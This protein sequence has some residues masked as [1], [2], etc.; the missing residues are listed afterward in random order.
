MQVLADQLL[1]GITLGAMYA[2]VA[3]GLA[4]IFSVVQLVNFSQGDSFMIG[5]YVFLIIFAGGAI[6]YPVAAVLCVAIMALFGVVFE[7]I[8]VRPIFD[9]PWYIQLLSTLAAS[10]ILR[11][12]ARLIWG[13]TP[14]ATPTSYVGAFLRI[15]RFEVSYQR[16][17]VLVVAVLSFL[18]LQL[19]LQRTRLGKAMR[20]VSQNREASS[21]VGIDIR[22]MSRLT[23]A[24]S[25]ALAGLGAVV[26]S[27]LFNIFPDMGASL[28]LRAFAA[29]V[30]GG[31]GQVKG[32]IY[33]ALLLGIAEALATGYVSAAYKDLVAFT[34]IVVVL[35]IRP[36]GLFGQRKVGSI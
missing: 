4:L 24:L 15:G 20:A 28:I 26:V 32:A 23:F 22:G 19:F 31:L 25:S 29:V 12:G 11:N 14:K 27:P 17:I 36:E 13:S 16:M 35:I 6:P 7:R 8:V 9:K 30:V 34:M 18:G 33:G 1:N 21:M 10:I 3:I 5:S 2:S